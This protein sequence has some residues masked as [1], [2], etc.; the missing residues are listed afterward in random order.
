MA[1]VK[2]GPRTF[3][4]TATRENG[5]WIIRVDGVG[6]TQARTYREI[7]TM[8]SGLV[9]A[10]LDI[11]PDTFV[12]ST[13]V[14]GVSDAVERMQSANEAADR[15]AQEAAVARRAAAVAA[16]KGAGLSVREA[17]AVLGL[18]HQRVTQLLNEDERARA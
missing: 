17:G 11:D 4:A 9:E 2:T 3:K 12:V 18:S 13:E 1:P 10:L 6:I 16:T 8:A 14:P 15:A 5:W 7:D